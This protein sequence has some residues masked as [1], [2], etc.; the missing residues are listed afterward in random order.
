[1][2]LTPST[3]LPL[4]H[5]LPAFRL[6]VVSGALTQRSPGTTSLIPELGRDDLPN[7]PVLVM[8]ICS[9]CPFVKHVEPELSRLERDYG[10]RVSLLAVSSNSVITH[11]QDG[12]EGLRQQAE[13]LGWAFPYLFDEQQ[14][15]AM[16]LRGACTPE[17]YLFS[18]DSS[19]QQTL[20]Y[21]GQLDGSRPGSAVELD[22][23]DLR[24]AMDAVLAGQPLEDQQ[25]PSIGCNIKWHPGQ[26]PP[27]FGSPA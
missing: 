24:H 25:H 18:P 6:P 23:R 16:A 1:M 13:R 21:R 17:F 22:G 10:Q 11:P 8:L 5:P 27:W 3:M 20:R 15:L 26:E 7:Q 2:V 14:S 19:A 12:P 9:H 4:G